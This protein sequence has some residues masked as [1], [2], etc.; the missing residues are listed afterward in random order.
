MRVR[1][2]GLEPLVFAGIIGIAVFLSIVVRVGAVDEKAL[3]QAECPYKAS[4]C[5]LGIVY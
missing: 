3:M 1:L 4:D 5:G 2:R